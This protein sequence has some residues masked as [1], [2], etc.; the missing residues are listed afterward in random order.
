M[1]RQIAFDDLAGLEA[2]ATAGFDP[3]GAPATIGADIAESFA[4]ISGAASG[5]GDTLPGYLVL[6]LVARLVPLPD[7]AVSGHSGALN[8]GCPTIR[9]PATA[10]VGASLQG[11]RRLCSA[12]EHPR[13]TLITL[14]FEVRE[15]GTEAPC[16]VAQNDLLYLSGQAR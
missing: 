13:G 7:W 12:R 2:I 11:R 16:M 8:L 14:E 1:T 3:W 5:A 4:Q 9:F 6:S 10:P 15:N